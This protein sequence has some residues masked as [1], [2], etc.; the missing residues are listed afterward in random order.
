MQAHNARQTCTVGIVGGSDL[1]KICEQLGADGTPQRVLSAQLAVISFSF[2]AV[3][4]YD[5]LFAENGLVAYKAG[6]L[7]C[8]KNLVSEL[9]EDKLRPFINFVLRYVADLEIPV[10][11]GTFLEFRA[12][13]INVRISLPRSAG[14]RLP[15][16]QR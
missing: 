4:A 9:G 14:P 2:A 15:T 1:V 6:E 8:K 3:T 13:M 11:R 7:L 12:G 10:K 5:Y 16:K